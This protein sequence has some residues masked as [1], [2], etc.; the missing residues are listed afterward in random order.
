MDS[1]IIKGGKPLNGQIKIS[2]AKNSAL[3]LMCASLLTAKPLILHNIPQL[4][5]IKTLSGLLE[6]HGVKITALSDNTLKLQADN[7]TNFT[8][9][10]ELV[11]QMRAS[12]IVLG[13]LLSRF[14]EA[15]VSLPGGCAIGT[16]PVDLHLKALEKMGAQIDIVDGYVIARAKKLKGAEI[17]FEKVSVGT[18]ENTLMAATLAQGETIL[19]NAAQ[20]PEITDLC[21]CLIKMGA[22]I[23][24]IG[25]NRL[26]IQGVAQLNGAEHETVADRIETGSLIVA[27]AI[28]RRRSR[29]TRRPR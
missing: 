24:G 7:I 26:T 3:K 16:R 23:D 19:S 10:Y 22:K 14:G 11:K 29:I 4:A 12:I 17:Y 13:P 8:A 1:L 20:E 5:D 21:Q 15:K 28:T 2:G 6:Q 9:P 27:S 18:T 25:T